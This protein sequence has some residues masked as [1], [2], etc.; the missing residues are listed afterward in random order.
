MDLFLLQSS[1]TSILAEL[2]HMP[3]FA[4]GLCETLALHGWVQCCELDLYRYYVYSMDEEIN[5]VML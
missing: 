2:M 5:V 3:H 1:A 4:A